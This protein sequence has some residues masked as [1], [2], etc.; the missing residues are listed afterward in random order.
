MRSIPHE[1]LNFWVWLQ[2]EY[3]FL[4]FFA[5]KIWIFFKAL[6]GNFREFLVQKG[7]A[8]HE[9]FE[10]PGLKST[11][12]PIEMVVSNIVIFTVEMIQFDEHIRQMGGEKKPTT[13]TKNLVEPVFSDVGATHG[14]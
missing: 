1:V 13:D 7:P 6:A 5:E 2:G 10:V 14:C 4:V 9:F 8:I 11:E 12:F 3:V